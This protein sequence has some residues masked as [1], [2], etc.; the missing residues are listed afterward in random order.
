M[1]NPLSIYTYPR[2]LEIIRAVTP[3]RTCL[4]PCQCIHVRAHLAVL[5]QQL[6]KSGTI[7]ALASDPT[8]IL[9]GL[10]PWNRGFESIEFYSTLNY[11][12]GTDY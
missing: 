12:L 2:L 11:L 10:F 6:L 5:F 3:E 4:T 8:V 9:I 7:T 1:S